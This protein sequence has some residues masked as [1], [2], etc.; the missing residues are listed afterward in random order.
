MAKLPGLCFPTRP[1]SVSSAPVLEP[2]FLDSAKYMRQE[3]SGGTQ[4]GKFPK[5]AEPSYYSKP[6]VGRQ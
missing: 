3:D 5:Q 1:D 6:E 2:V 4:T